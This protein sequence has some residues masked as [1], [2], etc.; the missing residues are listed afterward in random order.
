[1]SVEGS[2]PLTRGKWYAGRC[3]P[4]P[5]LAHPRSRGENFPKRFSK[6]PMV[7]SSPLT[8]G[9]FKPAI[10]KRVVVGLIPAH[11]GKMVTRLS[12]RRGARAHPRSRGENCCASHCLRVGEGSSPLTR[13]KCERAR[14]L[15]RPR[16]LIPAHAGKISGSPS[17]PRSS[18]AH[19]RSRGENKRACRAGGVHQGSSPLTRGK[20]LASGM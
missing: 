16:R 12:L 14:L 10:G 13:G 4:T 15:T 2:S 20:Y 6:P 17:R 3:K 11:A 7:G 1:M 5:A 8:R 9:K 18:A 19:P